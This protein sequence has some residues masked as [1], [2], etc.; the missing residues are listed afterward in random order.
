[1]AVP[2]AAVGVNFLRQVLGIVDEHVGLLGKLADSLVEDRIARLVIGG[3]NQ[4]GVARLQA[5]S[6][7]PLRMIQPHRLDD[8]IVK[9]RRPSAMP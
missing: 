8:A 3:V 7:A 6:K 5:E 1:M 9:G 4:D 2:P